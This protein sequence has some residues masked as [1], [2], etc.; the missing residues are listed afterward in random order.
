MN[1]LSSEV[2]RIIAH[3]M[4]SPLSAIRYALEALPT[5]HTDPRTL[6]DIRH[7]IARQIQQLSRLID[8]LLEAP[9]L[10]PGAFELHKKCMDVLS[11]VR[12][13]IETTRPLM[14]RFHHRL[15]TS[16]PTC[17]AP[18]DGD[19]DRLTQVFVN[20]LENPAHYTKPGGRIA[21]SVE[22]TCGEISV[23]VQDN[24]AGIPTEL[25]TRIFDMYVRGDEQVRSR[26]GG[27]G[28]GLTVARCI[29]EAHGGTI[30][31][32]SDG[33]GSGSVFVVRLP[34]RVVEQMP[35]TQEVQKTPPSVLLLKAD[36]AVRNATCL[37]LKSEGYDVT[38]VS[39]LSE[40]LQTL[41]ATPRPDLLVADNGNSG[42]EVL[43][44]LRK[45]LG[46]DLKAVLTS[47]DSDNPQPVANSHIR[48]A[49]S[50]KPNELLTLL[51]DLSRD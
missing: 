11:P 19:T 31:A 21:L 42:A 38:A 47:D 25:V 10:T 51:R 6:D 22:C 27:T 5:A 49:H 20:L 17:V 3:E 7:R 40:A 18:I 44:T 14:E 26:P 29:V 32:S 28:I 8:D 13:A 50:L 48:V 16:L 23:R 30:S 1:A 36:S 9:L 24:G 2:T 12:R 39:S 45:K 34:A 35:R 41:E 46:V 4:R 15:T 33:P 43:V 37:L